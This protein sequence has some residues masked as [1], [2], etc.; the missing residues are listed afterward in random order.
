MLEPRAERGR[1]EAV[2]RY[3]YQ[4]PA[5]A[6]HFTPRS[7]LSRTDSQLFGSTCGL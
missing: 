7:E 2:T 1:G 4:Q 3:K 6:K 5:A